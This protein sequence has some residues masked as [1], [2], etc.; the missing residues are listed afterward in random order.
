MHD[1]EP[2]RRLLDPMERLRDHYERLRGLSDALERQLEEKRRAVHD[3]IA[4]MP[5]CPFCRQPMN[6]EHFLE[7]D[8]G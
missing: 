2:L 8:H 3:L 6:A 5:L 4:A 7:A 1:P